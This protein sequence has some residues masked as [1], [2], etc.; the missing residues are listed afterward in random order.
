M[1]LY[2][3]VSSE[4]QNVEPALIAGSFFYSQLMRVSPILKD[5]FLRRSA[6]P[7]C[8]RK[9]SNILV[10]QIE[11]PSANIEVSFVTL[12]MALFPVFR[13]CTGQQSL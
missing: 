4:K 1:S 13:L 5:Y 11:V 8:L 12:T 6:L 3:K 2:F 10:E 7:S 9:T